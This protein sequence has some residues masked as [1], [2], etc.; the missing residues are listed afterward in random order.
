MNLDNSGSLVVTE[1]SPIRATE[2]RAKIRRNSPAIAEE[3]ED[4]CDESIEYIS[5]TPI[6]AVTP[7]YSFPYKVP[8]PDTAK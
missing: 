6:Q 5:H 8:L 4:F 2:I 7:T 1:R 3:K